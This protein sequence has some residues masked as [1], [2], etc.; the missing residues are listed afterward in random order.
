MTARK[1]AAQAVIAPKVAR[2][3]LLQVTVEMAMWTQESNVILEQTTELLGLR[4]M[5]L[6]IS[7]QC[8]RC[9]K[10]VTRIPS[11][12]NAQLPL[13]ALSRRPTETFALA[14]LGI[15]LMG[16]LQQIPSSSA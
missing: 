3:V 1:M 4:A 15:G 10:A 8:R 9:V 5:L 13:H 2:S 12:T 6:V 7:C 11:T 14:E 16:C